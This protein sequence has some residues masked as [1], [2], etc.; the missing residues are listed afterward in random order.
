MIYDEKENAISIYLCNFERPLCRKSPGCMRNGGSCYYTLDV[1]YAETD[2]DG[3]AIVA[4]YVTPKPIVAE[5]VTPEPN[6]N[7]EEE[8]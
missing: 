5:Y 6:V 3:I 4:E 1:N 8:K 7:E 2:A